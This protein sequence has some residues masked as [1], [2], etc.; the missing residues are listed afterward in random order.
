MSVIFEDKLFNYESPKI[1][2][3]GKKIVHSMISARL[4][5]A[6]HSYSESALILSDT[7]RPG[8]SGGNVGKER[9]MLA[10]SN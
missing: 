10:W 2:I 6:N 3:N 8:S 1:L 7:M 5:A 4:A 9:A